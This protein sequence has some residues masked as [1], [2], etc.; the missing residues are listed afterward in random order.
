MVVVCL[1]V[2]GE[3]VHLRLMYPYSF[4]PIIHT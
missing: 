1:L 3:Y 4:M 2:I